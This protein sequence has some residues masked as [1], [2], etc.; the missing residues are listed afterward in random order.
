MTATETDIELAQREELATFLGRV[1]RAA[2]VVTVGCQVI[3][4][5]CLLGHE[6]LAD[7][8]LADYPL[9]DYLLGVSVLGAF[10]QLLLIIR[11]K[12]RSQP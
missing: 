3:A 4:V 1:Q 8:P 12:R 2:F 5:S 9:G 11:S 10:I 6:P 7:Y